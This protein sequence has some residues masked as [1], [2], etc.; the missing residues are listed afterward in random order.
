MLL[1]TK[2]IKANFLKTGAFKP[3]TFLTEKKYKTREFDIKWLLMQS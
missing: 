2:K 1:K 3:L